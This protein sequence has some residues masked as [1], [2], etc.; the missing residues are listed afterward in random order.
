M[1]GNTGN[2]MCWGAA[3]VNI[4]QRD[5]KA[6]YRVAQIVDIVPYNRT[7]R[8]DREF[9]NVRGPGRGRHRRLLLDLQRRSRRMHTTAGAPA[10]DWQ[11]E[12]VLPHGV[13][14]QLAD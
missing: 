6:V 7:Y 12:A 1:L 3:S 10:A 2:A 8:L 5:A 9:S 13:C 11:L 14:V 4:G